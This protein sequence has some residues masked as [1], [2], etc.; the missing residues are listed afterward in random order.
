MFT[1][2][3]KHKKVH[4]KA[5]LGRAGEIQEVSLEKTYSSLKT[6]MKKILRIAGNLFKLIAY[7]AALRVIITFILLVQA[8]IVEAAFKC[9]SSSKSNKARLDL[10]KYLES[11]PN[12]SLLSQIEIQTHNCL[13]SNEEF[14]KM[15]N[16]SKSFLRK[17]SLPSV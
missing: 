15:V 3:E 4:G 11:R 1:H 17:I 6:P 13:H 12:L 10:Q 8:L 9:G 2:S 16:D 5:L 14:V 7:R